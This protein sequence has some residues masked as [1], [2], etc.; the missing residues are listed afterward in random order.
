VTQQ[1]D[2]GARIALALAAGL[3]A[4]CDGG[5]STGPTG[6]GG[7]RVVAG[8]NVTDT[9]LAQP[10]QA[11]IL[12]VRAP[13]GSVARDAVVRFEPAPPAD[14]LRRGERAIYVCSLAA[15][16]CGP[17]TDPFPAVN[18]LFA[19]D[20]TDA[21]GRVRVL[22]RLGTVAGPAAIVVTVPEH[23]LRDTVRYTVTAGG[24]TRLRFTA[25]DTMAYEGATVRLGAALR[26]RFGNPRGE[27]L[28]Y[29]AADPGVLAVDAAGVARAAALG[30]TR[31]V[32]RFGAL[33]DTAAVSVVPRGRLVAWA[34]GDAGGQIVL[35]NLDGSGFRRLT[36]NPS[37][38]GAFPV[39]SP[40]GSR[41]LFHTGSPVVDVIDS[42]GAGRRTVGQPGSWFA[43]STPDEREIRFVA[44]RPGAGVAAWRAN[45][46]GSQ[47][48]ALATLPDFAGYPAGGAAFS[49]AGD[50]VAYSSAGGL[51][52]VD[53]VT[54]RV[55][56][57]GG[58]GVAPRWS[59]SGERV[60]FAAGFDGVVTLVNADG[61]GRQALT[62]DA[63]S[64]GL[65][66]SPDGEWVLGRRGASGGA[67]LV[68]VRVRDRLTL[69][70]RFSLDL[71]QP[72][73]R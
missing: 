10:L 2:A 4:A 66:W 24:A 44:P 53:L 69:P 46:D 59:P 68:L 47:P 72:S 15:P 55:A 56:T 41:V 9:V 61:S 21:A 11:L 13:D 57:A 36:P 16:G 6:R 50:R 45:A 37:G 43:Q 52:I 20:T 17:G 18:G 25:R 62:P 67:R 60:A 38:W 51:R 33:A 48:A 64:P 49:P 71:Y 73:W 35:V 70:L 63:Y 39:W 3:A 31:V 34:A 58:G 5:D 8:A 54:G 22:V 12:E 29:V 7:I 40:G 1:K 14:T 28:T 26:D 42:T 30:R 32:A 27:P 23:A 19:A 65:A